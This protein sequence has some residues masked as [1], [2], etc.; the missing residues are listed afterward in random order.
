MSFG[1]SVGDLI[2]AANLTY[3]LIAALRENHD[4]GEEYRSA[5]DELGCYQTALMK[6]S[7]LGR[8]NNVPRDT[9]DAASH[10][11]MQS[12]DMIQSY[13]DQTKKYDQ[14]LGRDASGFRSGFRKVRWTLIKADDMKKLR[15]SL[16]RRNAGLQ[17]LLQCAGFE[18]DSAPP[19]YVGDVR[20]MDSVSLPT[21][22]NGLPDHDKDSATGEDVPVGPSAG[23]HGN[24]SSSSKSTGNPPTLPGVTEPST[25]PNV[26]KSSTLPDVTKSSTLP[27]VTDP[28]ILPNIIEPPTSKLF[29]LSSFSAEQLRSLISNQASREHEIRTLSTLLRTLVKL[30]DYQLEDRNSTD[31]LTQLDSICDNSEVPKLSKSIKFKD[32][33][34]RKFSFPW[35]LAQTWNVRVLGR[36]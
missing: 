26:T 11:V 9:F 7:Y 10:M 18:T 31:F 4:A 17:L 5:I 29:S 24:A 22:R 14:K 33:V 21:T 1:F 35:R 16:Q 30:G 27:D 23:L 34:G 28:S 25:L 8:N 2:G 3:R 15:D 13:L 32:A 6:V 20:Q 36:H 12:M 19:K